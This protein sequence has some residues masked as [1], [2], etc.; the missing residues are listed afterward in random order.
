MKNARKLNVVECEG[1]PREIGRQYGDSCRENLNNSLEK[2]FAGFQFVYQAGKDKIITNAMKFLPL[3]KDF[4]PYFIEI[5]EGM[6]EG[7]GISFEEVFTLR[8]SMELTFHYNTING[9]CT[10]FAVSGKHTRDGKTILGQNIDWQPDTTL[11]LLK[12]HHQNGSVQLALCIGGF[13]EYVLSSAGFGMCANATFGTDFKMNLPLGCYLPKAMRQKSLPEA[14]EVLKQSARGLG[15]YHLAAKDGEIQGIESVSDDYEIMHPDQ[16]VMV[17]ANHYLTERFMDKDLVNMV[18]PDSIHRVERMR[19]LIKANLVDIN[20]ELMMK[21]MSDHDREP[22]SIC[23]HVDMSKPP[24]FHS[25]TIGSFI[26]V[27]EDGL[28]YIAYGNPCETEY[29]KYSL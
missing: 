14:M 1:S 22:N 25:E 2:A 23:R 20:P 12:I 17:H 28:M 16:N 6:A 4:D 19:S 5:M 24:Q 15:Y 10:S 9:L 3:V 18:I 26:M 21:F 13:V 27:P 8:S 7:A 29:I 11:D